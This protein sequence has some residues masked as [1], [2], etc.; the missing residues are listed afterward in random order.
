M[1]PA[2]SR[3][4]DL[5]RSLE[6]CAYL[7]VHAPRQSGKTTAMRALARRLTAEGHY[8]ALHFSCESAR[9]FSD[10]GSAERQIWQVIQE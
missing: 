6:R 9:A 3:T 4:P 7:G 10:I 1:V 5:G 8:A 2:E